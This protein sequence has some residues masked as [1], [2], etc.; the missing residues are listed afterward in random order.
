[1]TERDLE[2]GDLVEPD[3]FKTIL[4]NGLVCRI[5]RMRDGHDIILTT[6]V[7]HHNRSLIGSKMHMYKSKVRLASIKFKFRRR[8]HLCGSA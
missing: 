5:E 6:V 7:K 3:P 2:V 4:G 8:S 1:M